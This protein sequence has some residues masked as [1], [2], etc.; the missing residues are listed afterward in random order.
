[1]GFLCCVVILIWGRGGLGTLFG[2]WGWRWRATLCWFSLARFGCVVCGGFGSF[3]IGSR[4]RGPFGRSGEIIDCVSVVSR[5]FSVFNLEVEILDLFLLV[6][7]THD[8]ITSIGHLV[9]VCIVS[10]WSCSFWF[11]NL[12]S[13]LAC[14]LPFLNLIFFLLNLHFSHR[15]TLNL[16]VAGFVG[17]LTFLLF[18]CI[19]LL[20]SLGGQIAVKR[21]SLL[22][23]ICPRFACF[24]KFE[25]WVPPAIVLL[26]AGTPGILFGW[27]RLWIAHLECVAWLWYL[28]GVRGLSSLCL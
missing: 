18:L 6:I 12:C 3:G 23:C 21:S 15:V 13:F 10:L 17:C 11:L 1:M 9:S 8:H 25:I 5:G 28:F 20:L 26:V 7:N 24:F 2:S 4:W 22:F 19:S 16:L 27:V 14:L